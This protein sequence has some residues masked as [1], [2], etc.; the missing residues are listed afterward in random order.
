MRVQ[1][2]SDYARGGGAEVHLHALAGL[3][4][5]NGD[6][7]DIL[8]GTCRPVHYASRI[9]NPWL[10]LVAWNRYRAFR[11]DV[12]HVHKYNLVWSVAPFLAAKALRIPVVCTQH[13]F[14]AVCPE[15][16]MVRK[17][18]TVC[19]LGFGGQCFSTRCLRSTTPALDLHRRFNSVRLAIQVP[20]LRRTV[21]VFTAPSR[22]L[23]DW[24][25]RLYPGVES[26]PLPLFVDP[27][28]A[29][30]GQAPVDPVTLFHAGR[31]EREKGLDIL[32][33]AMAKVQDIRLRVAGDGAARSG[34]MELCGS[35][36]IRD[37]VDWL[38]PVDRTRVLQECC[39]AHLAVLPSLWVE[40]APLFVLE[41]MREGCPVAASDVGGYPDLI[42][43]GV[44][45]FLVERGSV[46]AWSGLLLRLASG[47]DRA[48]MGDAAR[49]R[50]VRDH[51]PEI[52]LRGIREIYRKALAIRGTRRG[53]LADT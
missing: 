12:V 47:F 35:L 42:D 18:G 41:A 26:G 16:W 13:D 4:G 34:L 31:I 29:T 6:P 32:L 8:T 9:F 51:S 27:P 14:G 11:P 45:G 10:A 19:Q 36:G 1:L 52:F 22:F 44:E 5:R 17:D 24:V 3:L 46:D 39:R 37:R 28:E 30:T 40:N 23:S 15:G 38:G 20:V 2:V 50:I 7:V 48:S 53:S 49:S 33:R 43:P 21:S 25:G